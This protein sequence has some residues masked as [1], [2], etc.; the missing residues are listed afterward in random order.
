MSEAASFHEWAI[1]DLFGHQRIAGRVSEQTIGGAS[2]VRV[3]VPETSAGPGF[4]R[5]FGPGAIYSVIICDEESA[6]LAAAAGTPLPMDRWT[7]QDLMAKQKPQLSPGD[8]PERF[9]LCAE[10]Q[11]DNHDECHGALCGCT[12]EESEMSDPEVLG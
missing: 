8:T 9:P 4:T 2:F 10:C 11:V 3:D 5:L 1:V 7:I 12:C 6:R